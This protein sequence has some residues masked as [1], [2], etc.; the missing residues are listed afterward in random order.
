MVPRVPLTPAQRE[1][2]E[3]NLDL[4]HHLALTAWRRNPQAIDRAEII[5]V[6][7]E[8]LTLAASRFD[9]ARA[10]IKDG[11]PDVSGAFSGYARRR[12][13]GIIMDWQRSRDHV[14]RRQRST[15][16]ELQQHGYGTGRTPSELAD[17]TGMEE[18][19]IRLVVAAVEAEPIPLIYAPTTMEAGRTEVEMTQHL[20]TPEVEAIAL[21]SR[22]GEV[23]I[24]TFD[25]L[26][27]F[28]RLVI[29]LRYYEGEDLTTIATVLETT[30]TQVRV[31]H[32][33]ALLH[34]HAAMVFEAS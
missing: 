6:A 13:N 14:P 10:E 3:K 19:R 4:A 34:L 32:S 18:D 33:E 27:D 16:K 7:Y 2:V 23:V 20:P 22:I 25:S 11:R 30:L 8:G 15:Y 31:A 17:L 26:S 1:L 29:A 24:A 9:P 21:V 28:Q 12:I 5:S